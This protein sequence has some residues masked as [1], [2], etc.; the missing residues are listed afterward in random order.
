V[1]EPFVVGV[2]GG[3]GAGKT[4]LARRVAARLDA[5]VTRVAL[6]DYYEARPDLSAEERRQINYDHPA[7]FDWDLLVEQ[8][9]RLRAGQA[10]E[11]PEYDFSVD[12][13]AGTRRVQ[14]GAVVVV[15]G[16]LALHDERV[17]EQ[18][19]LCVYVETDADVRVIRRVRR[20]V[21]ERDREVEGVVD[22]YLST[23]KPMHERHV[24][25]T[26]G[27]ADVVIPEGANER[28]VRLLADRLRAALG[29][30][31][32]GATD[33]TETAEAAANEDP[34]QSASR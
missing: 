20:D 23:V 21:L 33:P 11:M 6:D 2:A 14:A 32:T 3:T 27:H 26:K 16:I 25:P 17:R 8:L 28:A 5:P 34:E 7:A 12:D 1:T 24:A 15:E 13:R 18:F 4:T 31:E 29:D 10:V 22:Q 9:R 19:D 30:P